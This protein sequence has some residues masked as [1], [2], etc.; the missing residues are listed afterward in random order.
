MTRIPKIALL[1]G[2]AVLGLFL[3]CIVLAGLFFNPNDYKPAIERWVEA[4]T[5]R[6][7]TLDGELGWQLWPHLAVTLPHTRLGPPTAFAGTDF[8]E[9]QQASISVRLWPLL[10]R[11]LELGEF[12]LRGLRLTL[13]RDAQGRDNWQDLLQ[14]MTQNQTPGRFRFGMLAGLQIQDAQLQLR[15]ELTQRAITLQLATL[16]SDAVQFD[17]PVMLECTCRLHVAAGRQYLELPMQL[18]A[19][20]QADQAVQ[21]LQL[22]LQGT[23]Q[24]RTEGLLAPLT[25]TAP[26]P[27][28]IALTSL[29]WQAGQQQLQV[30]SLR[31]EAGTAQLT[32]QLGATQMNARPALVASWQLAVPNLRQWLQTL[33]VN[34][35]I[36]RDATVL[37]HLQTALQLSGPAD[38]LHIQLSRMK[39]DQTR[40]EGEGRRL[41]S[42][43]LPHYTFALHA[44]QLNLDRYLPAEVPKETTDS[45]RAAGTSVPIEWLRSL[46]AQG[47]LLIDRAQWQGITARH[48]KIELDG[49]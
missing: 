40:F 5:G 7:F 26:L 39:L 31:L 1:A 12:R 35:P 36:T 47:S 30:K 18:T 22:D 23:G 4:Q 25:I 11:R 17:Q 48:L 24:L 20:W 28:A 19:Q 29:S 32:G 42:D 46:Q 33:G 3:L 14:L 45:S 16:Q 2:A 21:R 49:E 43:G 13:Q 37:Q 44:D 6:S 10:Q 15:D 9:W 38:D 34:V 41:L 27:L 8:A